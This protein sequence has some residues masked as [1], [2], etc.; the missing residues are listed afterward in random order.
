MSIFDK[1]KEAEQ[2]AAK[3]LTRAEKIK[4][5]FIFKVRPYLM[6]ILLKAGLKLIDVLILYA[7][8]KLFNI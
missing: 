3:P 8:I 4:K 7:L 5:F 2:S 1:I 6:G